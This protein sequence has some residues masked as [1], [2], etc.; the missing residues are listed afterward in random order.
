MY[1]MNEDQLRTIELVRAMLEYGTDEMRSLA[2]AM[3]REVAY[4][5]R[6]RVPMRTRPRCET[7]I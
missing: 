3:L 5:I 1:E 7:N 6:E 2:V 4:E